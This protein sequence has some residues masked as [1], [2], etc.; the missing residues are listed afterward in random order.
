MVILFFIQ[1]MK[2]EKLMKFLRQK[3]QGYASIGN[4]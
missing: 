2:V 4:L 1:I 3:K